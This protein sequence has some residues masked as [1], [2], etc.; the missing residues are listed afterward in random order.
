MTTAGLACRSDARHAPSRAL[1]AF[2]PHTLL[3]ALPAAVYTPDAEGR[4]SFA[5]AA[6]VAFWGR[7]PETGRERYCGALR[8]FWPDGRPMTHDE[9]FMAQALRE[10][11]AI[12]GEA[13]AERPD[14]TRFPFLAFA[15]PLRDAVGACAGAVN[16]LVD[17]SERKNA[18][19]HEKAL[20]DEL[21][22]R[23][24]NALATVQAIAYQT[25]RA[26]RVAADAREAFEGRLYALSRA[27]DRLSAENWGSADLETIARNICEPCC[28]GRQLSISGD[29]VRVEPR[30]ALT[31][32]MVFHELATNAVRHGALAAKGG[33]VTLTWKAEGDPERE[34]TILWSERRSWNAIRTGRGGFGTRLLERGITQELGGSA[35]V[36]FTA[37][38]MCCRMVIPLGRA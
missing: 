37:T 17:I 18:E 10:N 22:H 21:N 31:L 2:S 6:A 30:T 25:L 38:G 33:S 24:K 9:C 4:I 11:R 7:E 34:L 35:A 20:L 16:M 15:T 13:I 28:T 14:G 1:A 23:V 8:L 3:S 32:A 36:N 27:H 26:H 12:S 29:P 19:R 5:N